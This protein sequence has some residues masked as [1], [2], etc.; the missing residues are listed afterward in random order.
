MQNVECK[1][2]LRDLSL[3]RGLAKLSGASFIA[4]LKQTDTYY[5]LTA[6]RLKRRET[7]GE[8]PEWVYYERANDARPR[9]SQF[10]IYSEEEALER[11]GTQQLPVW[12]VVSKK[13]ELYMYENVRIHLDVV[14][15]LGT[16]VE[17]E[18][19]VTEAYHIGRCQHSV[20]FLKQHFGPAL[21]ETIAVSYCDMMAAAQEADKAAM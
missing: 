8:P 21:G 1:Y 2:E 12:V 10:V 3:A 18:A 20:N 6:G 7:E 9:I 19:L 4:T 11:Y 17:F 5:K 15:A 13:R 14:E 16:F